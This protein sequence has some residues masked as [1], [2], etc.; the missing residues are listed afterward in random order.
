MS[1]PG[2]TGSVRTLRKALFTSSPS[3]PAFNTSPSP[4]SFKFHSLSLVSSFTILSKLVVS[5]H[6]PYLLSHSFSLACIPYSFSSQ[7]QS[8]FLAPAVFDRLREQHREQSRIEKI[9][10]QR[11]SSNIDVCLANSV[12]R[13]AS[14]A[15]ERVPDRHD[16]GVKSKT[17]QLSVSHRRPRPV[18]IG[19]SV[20]N[21]R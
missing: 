8:R 21:R 2:R 6:S 19:P 14:L 4:F 1:S 12:G 15:N 13:T 5:F 16:L 3:E 10:R 7:S 9:K 17:E 18:G 11:F 20:A